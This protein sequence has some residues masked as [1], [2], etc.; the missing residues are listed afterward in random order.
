[1]RKEA[2]WLISNIAA[3]N[4]SQ[5]EMIVCNFYYVSVL[6][7]ILY[8]DSVEVTSSFIKIL[9]LKRLVMKLH[10]RYVI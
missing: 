9:I 4:E 8:Q 2:C 7:K 6:K 3:G 10:G 5:V 1:M